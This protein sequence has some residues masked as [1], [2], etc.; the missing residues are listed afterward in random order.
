MALSPAPRQFNSTVEEVKPISMETDRGGSVKWEEKVIHSHSYRCPEPFAYLSVVVLGAGA[1]GVDISFQLVRDKAQVILSLNK[2][3]LSFALSLEIKQASLVV[4]VLD[5]GFL[6][7]QDGSVAHSQVPLLCTG[8]NYHF[9]FSA[10]RSIENGFSLKRVF[11]TNQPMEEEVDSS[12][13]E[14]QNADDPA[15]SGASFVA[16]NQPQHLQKPYTQ[17]QDLPIMHWEDLSLRIAELEKQEEERRK[18]AEFMVLPDQEI[19]PGHWHHVKHQSFSKTP[20]EDGDNLG[21]HRFP[22]IT[23]RFNSS[24]KLQLC[25]INDTE[26]DQESDEGASFK[27]KTHESTG[28]RRQSAGLKQ[29][30]R[31]ALS[32]LR[33]KLWAEQ[34]QQ[35]Q[36]KH[37]DVSFR[38]RK[39]SRSDLQ[40]CSVLQL[41]A[42]KTSLNKDIQ[43]DGNGKNA[44]MENGLNQVGREMYT[45]CFDVA[46]DTEFSE[47]IPYGIVL[48]LLG[49]FVPFI[50]IAWCYS[51]VVWT[52]FQ[53]L[54]T[55]PYTQ[56]AGDNKKGPATQTS[57]SISGSQNAP[58]ISRRRKSI[59]TIITITFLFALCFLPFH[60]TR[61]LYLI[62]K[63]RNAECHTIHAISVCYKV[64][65]P[66][67]SFNSWLNALLYFLTGDNSI[68][69]CGLTETSHHM[70]HV[71]PTRANGEMKEEV[72]AEKRKQGA[73]QTN[74]QQRN[75]KPLGITQRTVNITK[76][77]AW[78][79]SYELSVSD[80]L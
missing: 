36:L 27:E 44:T 45:N 70:H 47:Y 63:Q 21:G 59:K 20:W 9:S 8:Y 11:V 5:D 29:E 65:R 57:L 76:P 15:L 66:L 7:F 30:V 80:Q 13:Q 62:L 74:N 2:P 16:Q 79:L 33:D 41:N 35:Q 64:T 24:K 50:V 43:V 48:H 56:E 4:K 46:T 6:L 19:V 26:S 37:K 18:N 32:E 75:T 17:D 22:C 67:A 1:S 51:Q 31:A 42:L 14:E 55:Q 61:T 12:G 34:R 60:I 25:F 68:S 40:T 52:I 38:R 3:S 72:V 49:F 78:W 77:C 71:W 39:L 28:Q 73:K 53:T 58:Y 69:C 10:W 23:S 54:H